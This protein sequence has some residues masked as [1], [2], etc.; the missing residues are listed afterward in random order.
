MC[1]VGWW[2]EGDDLTSSL[3]HTIK[4]QE[5]TCK[6]LLGDSDLGVDTC[7][8]FDMIA[9]KK[10]TTSLKGVHKTSN[11]GFDDLLMVHSRR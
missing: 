9:T 3:K 2:M 1:Y 8:P 11:V 4:V 5:E 6:A 7:T 10:E